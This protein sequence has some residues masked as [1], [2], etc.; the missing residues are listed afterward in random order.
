MLT[1]ITV[2]NQNQIIF[3][4]IKIQ[5]CKNN[6]GAIIDTD[7]QSADPECINEIKIALDEFGVVFFRNQNLD[8]SAYVSFAKQFGT[9]ADYPMLEGLNKFPEITVVEKKPEEQIMF[10]EGWHTDS[11]Y[12][13]EPPQYTMLYSIKSPPK[14]RV[15]LYL[16]LS[17]K[18][19]KNFPM[20]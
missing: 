12:T 1:L 6:V 19:I 10:G 14:V 18:V 9:P 17:M 20:N 15:I 3:K 16:R 5:P 8:S 4:S 11:T 13:P 2:K 7:I